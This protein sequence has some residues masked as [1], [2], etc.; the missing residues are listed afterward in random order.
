M[1]KRRIV[2]KLNNIIFLDLEATSRNAMQAQPIELAAI[3]INGE[4]LEIHSNGEFQSLMQPMFDEEECKKKGVDP[5]T[6]EVVKITGIKP[7]DLEDAPSVKVVWKNFCNWVEQ[8]K[9]ENSQWGN[10]YL[11]GYNIIGYDEKIINRLCGAKPYNFGPWDKEFQN[12]KLFHP[13]HKIDLMH[14]AW[15]WF[16]HRKN[17]YSISFDSLRSMFNLSTQDSHRAMIDVKQGTELL[18]RFM[19][20]YRNLDNKVKWN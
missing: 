18:I 2:I 8:F 20:L 10:P 16:A 11:S 4:S 5:L 7:E 9:T 6:D 12:N 19:K 1:R 17:V 3:A 14:D 15:R 13:I